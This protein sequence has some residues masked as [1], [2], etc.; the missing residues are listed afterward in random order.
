MSIT[1]SYLTERLN[2]MIWDESPPILD[3]PPS[4]EDEA[5]AGAG[6]VAS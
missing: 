4:N 3:E 1:P 6:G 5:L 2:K